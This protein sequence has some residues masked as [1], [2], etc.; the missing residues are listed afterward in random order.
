MSI[1]RRG[2]I[3]WFLLQYLRIDKSLG[4]QKL[5]RQI[6]WR[7]AQKRPST[8]ISQNASWSLC[9]DWAARRNVYIRR[10]LQVETNKIYSRP[11]DK[12][13]NI[14]FE[15]IKVLKLIQYWFRYKISK[16]KAMKFSLHCLKVVLEFRM[17]YWLFT[18][19]CIY[20]QRLIVVIFN[21]DAKL[22]NRVSIRGKNM[23]RM[24]V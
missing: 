15:T 9:N 22:I 21:V 17:F 6:D 24:N 7:L 14:I 16:S 12:I 5:N 20:C 8:W 23:D 11:M 3:F 13:Y 4:S 18:N 2:K 1:Q 19:F 10:W